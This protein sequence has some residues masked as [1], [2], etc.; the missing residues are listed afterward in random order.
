MQRTDD[1]GGVGV[2]GLRERGSVHACVWAL[3]VVPDVL[4]VEMS[5]S[6]VVSTASA[7]EKS[8]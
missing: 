1:V 4:H 5:D 7:L 3:W 2:P 6:G 8:L